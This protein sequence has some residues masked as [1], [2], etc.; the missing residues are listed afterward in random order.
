LAIYRRDVRI[1]SMCLLFVFRLYG[2]NSLATSEHK[3][4]PPVPSAEEESK[5]WL[6][7]LKINFFDFFFFFL[8]LFLKIHVYSRNSLFISMPPPP[9]LFSLLWSVFASKLD[10]PHWDVSYYLL[11][12]VLA[13]GSQ[14]SKQ[15]YYRIW[16][17]T[18]RNDFFFLKNNIFRCFYFS[19]CLWHKT[20]WHRRLLLLSFSFLWQFR[21]K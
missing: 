9:C 17:W 8:L 19:S 15:I 13:K 10:L 2:P 5:F 4:E 18:K 16:F 6:I 12:N 20:L 1:I 3:P 21:C 7:I 11:E 14:F